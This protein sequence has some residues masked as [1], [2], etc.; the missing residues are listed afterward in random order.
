[1]DQQSLRIA[2]ADR[3]QDV[4][5]RMGMARIFGE[6]FTQWL[7]FFSKDSEK[8]A[9]AFAH[10]FV[11]DQ[12][13]VA[14]I[15]GEVAGMAACT[16]SKSLSMR[17]DRGELRRHFGWYRGVIAGIALKKEFEA[18]FL[19]QPLNAGSI[20]FVGTASRYLWQ[21]VASQLLRYVIENTSFKEFLIEEVADTN[22]PAVNLYRKLGFAEYKSKPL[23]AK[24]AAKIGI[25][26]F[27][28]FRHVP[29]RG[30]RTQK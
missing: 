7:G 22:L 23:P 28:S 25:N 10:S 17:L 24:Q 4:S 9:R 14:L 30:N 27:V 13:Y 26:R 6:G 11:L 20:E 3:V 29:T 15:D 12:F 5:V 1:M 2:R 16:D 19:N 8:I 21:G 18:P